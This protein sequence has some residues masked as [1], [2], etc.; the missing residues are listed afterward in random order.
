MEY[1]VQKLAGLAGISTRTLR[2]YDDIGLLKPRRTSTSG[3]RLY[4]A[5]E[6]DRLQQ[7]LFYREL[8][9][10]LEEIKAIV[11]SSAFN[12]TA[13]L[14]HH[15]ERLLDKKKQLELLIANVEKSL[16]GAEGRNIMS[17]QEKF[18]GFKQKLIEE[19]EQKYGAEVRA[20]YGSEVID[21][22][23]KRMKNMTEDQYKGVQKLSG[24][25]NAAIKAAFEVGDPGSGLA[26]KA[27][28]LHKQWLLKFWDEYSPEAHLALTQMYVD[29][30]RF[31]AYYDKI[32]PG[33]AVY[34]L[35]AMRIYTGAQD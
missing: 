2:Y 27:C 23:N 14:R 15:H 29:D 17:D 6:V 34:F 22:S 5:E 26:R 16:A 1:T 10:G 28:E 9:V 20:K 30:D 21:R 19:N 11:T 32:V 7:I 31:T 24:E 25:V 12:R 33:C 3:Y 4:G 13:A 18:E 8:G 35:K